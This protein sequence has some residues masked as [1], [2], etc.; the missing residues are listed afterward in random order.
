MK[1]Y[2]VHTRD[3]FEESKGYEFFSSKSEAMKEKRRNDRLF[4]ANQQKEDVR[5]YEFKLTK[6]SVIEMLNDLA[7]HPDNG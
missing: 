4:P 7:S 3:D 5:E 2:I 1:V 6:K